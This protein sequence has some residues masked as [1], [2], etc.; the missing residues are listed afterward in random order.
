MEDYET[1]L[2]IYHTHIGREIDTIKEHKYIYETDEHPMHPDL[3]ISLCQ[4]NGFNYRN[5]KDYSSYLKR[6]SKRYKQNKNLNGEV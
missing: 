1:M 5:G 6:W 3:Y 4:V 2:N